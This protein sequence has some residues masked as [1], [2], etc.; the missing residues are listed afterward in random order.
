MTQKPSYAEQPISTVAALTAPEASID[1]RQ[2]SK[3]I[4]SST[5]QREHTKAE[6]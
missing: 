6:A 5:G 2:L 1:L 3:P 4:Y